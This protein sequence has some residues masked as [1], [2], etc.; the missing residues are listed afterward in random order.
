MKQYAIL[1]GLSFI[2]FFVDL[3]IGLL[4]H[5]AFIE[6]VTFRQ[7]AEW[8][9]WAH[10]VYQLP[11]I[12]FYVLVGFLF[13]QLSPYKS[14]WS[15]V[16]LMILV[17]VWRLIFTETIWVIE[18]SLADRIWDKVFLL[19]PSVSVVLGW[20]AHRQFASGFARD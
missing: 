15:I 13:A 14:F 8:F 16:R 12:L 7:S 17:L 20:Y 9:S 19:L 18:P 4:W 6:G 11:V 10:L 1:V 2:A 3:G 5:H